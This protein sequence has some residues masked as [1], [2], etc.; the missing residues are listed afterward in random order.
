M[1]LSNHVLSA[2]VTVLI[3]ES[4]P[5]LVHHQRGGHGGIVL[6]RDI[7]PIRVLS[8]RKDVA[9]DVEG[10]AYLAFGNAVLRHGIGSKPVLGVGIHA[11][12]LRDVAAAAAAAPSSTAASL[13]TAAAMAN[14]AG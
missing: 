11:G 6:G 5:I 10:A 12:G 7:D 14:C 1:R 2:Q 3:L 8:S 9:P 4:L 13:S